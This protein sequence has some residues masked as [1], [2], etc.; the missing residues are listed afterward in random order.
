M[1]VERRFAFSRHVD[2]ILKNATAL[3]GK[4][5]R[6]FHSSIILG[7]DIISLWLSSIIQ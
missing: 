7:F 3:L 5:V 6:I 1:T 4:Y 2:A